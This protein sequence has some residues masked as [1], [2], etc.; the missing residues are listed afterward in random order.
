MPLSLQDENLNLK[1]NNDISILRSYKR[2][3]NKNNKLQKLDD[4]HINDS[5]RNA[6]QLGVIY[7]KNKIRKCV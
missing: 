2:R 5:R 7:L 4:F 6:D 3:I 1:H